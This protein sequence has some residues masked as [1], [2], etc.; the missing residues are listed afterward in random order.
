M[1]ILLSILI[2]LGLFFSIGAMAQDDDLNDEPAPTEEMA[3]GGDD[4]GGDAAMSGDHEDMKS[5]HEDKKA[6][7]PVGKK[8]KHAKKKKK[9]NKK[10]KG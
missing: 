10:K 4:M 2:S 7:K 3:P 1:K 5:A 6:D 9:K 8:V